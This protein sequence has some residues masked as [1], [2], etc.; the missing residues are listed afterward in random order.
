MTNL[1]NEVPNY[2]LSTVVRNLMSYTLIVPVCQ[3]ATGS[4]LVV[5]VPPKEQLQDH[6]V[7]SKTT[8][9]RHGSICLL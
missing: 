2:L 3:L 1:E 5:L 9:Q 7:A 8:P 6:E 4:N